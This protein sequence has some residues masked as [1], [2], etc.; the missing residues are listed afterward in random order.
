MLESHIIQARARA[1]ATENQAYERMKEEMGDVYDHQGLIT[2]ELETLP[3]IDI[4]CCTAD[5]SAVLCWDVIMFFNWSLMSILSQISL[6]LVC[7]QWSSQNEQPDFPPGLL[8]NTKTSS[9]SASC[10]YTI[11]FGTRLKLLMTSVFWFNISPLFFFFFI[12]FLP[13]KCN[14][15]KPTIA[16][17]MHVSREPQDDGYTLIPSPEMMAPERNVSDISLTL[18]SSSDTPKRK[19]TPREVKSQRPII[20]EFIQCIFLI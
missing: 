16:Y 18:E 7:R 5:V 8:N 6:S 17:T 13:V 3:R 20:H 10:K 15:A 9:G 19:K 2:G 1:A 4:M 11:L 12:I 14:P